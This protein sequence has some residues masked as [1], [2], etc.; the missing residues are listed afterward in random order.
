MAD[1]GGQCQLAVYNAVTAK[2][3]LMGQSI[4]N[5]IVTVLII[6]F[7]IMIYTMIVFLIG[8]NFGYNQKNKAAPEKMTITPVALTEK[9][10]M[11][12][13]TYTSVRKLKQ[14]KFEYSTKIDGCWPYWD[15]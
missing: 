6:I 1:I 4:Q 10:T 12:P 3:I 7:V 11:T 5:I 14:P 2:E 9:M 15:P 8:C 13:V